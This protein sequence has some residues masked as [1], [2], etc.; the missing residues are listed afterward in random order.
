VAIIRCY[1]SYL[2]L[3][4][5]H[6]RGLRMK[7][8]LFLVG[9]LLCVGCTRS[10]DGLFYDSC[11]LYHRP[12]VALLLKSDR[13]FQYKFSYYDTLIQGNWRRSHDTITLHSASFL[14]P[15][16]PLSPRLKY[17]SNDSID[18][19][20]VVRKKLIPVPSH[21]RQAQGCFLQKQAK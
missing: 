10:Y 1:F 16:F 7:C 15:R 17:T 3:V 9:S 20:L 14:L 8:L 18:Q 13:T 5:C 21:G 12:A 19:F 4:F 6:F 2:N 11:T